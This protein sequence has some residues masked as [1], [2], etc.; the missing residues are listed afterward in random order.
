MKICRSEVIIPDMEG[1]CELLRISYKKSGAYA[2]IPSSIIQKFHRDKER[3]HSF[4]AFFKDGLLVLFKDTEL[5][6]KLKPEILASR[7]IYEKLK[8]VDSSITKK[9]YTTTMGV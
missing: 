1:Q 9:V 3:N 5:E 4:V 6:R 8:E 7:K 2:Y